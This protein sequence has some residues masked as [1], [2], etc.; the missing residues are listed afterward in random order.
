MKELEGPKHPS[1]VAFLEVLIV[2]ILLTETVYNTIMRVQYLYNSIKRA[3][4]NTISNFHVQVT[5]LFT[6]V[7]H[8][9]HVS[10]EDE[11]D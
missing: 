8:F 2:C 11:S 4:M 3:F 6:T 10:N 9:N 1:F 7:Y 5:W